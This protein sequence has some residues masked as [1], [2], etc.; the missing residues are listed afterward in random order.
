MS[1]IQILVYTGG[2]TDLY[3]RIRS[4][5]SNL[6]PAD[7][8]TVFHISADT[9]KKQPWMEPN[10][11]CLIVADTSQLDDQLCTIIQTYLS[12][13]GKVMLLCQKR[14]LADLSCCES[15][16]KQAGMIRMVF[17]PQDFNSTAKDFELFLRNSLKTLSEQGNKVRYGEA[18][19]LKPKLFLQKTKEMGKQDMP[20]VTE[21]LL[22]VGILPRSNNSTYTHFN[23]PLYFSRLKTKHL[24]RIIMHIPV[25]TTTIDICA[26]LCDAI[27][28]STGAVIVAARQTH[29]RGRSGNEFLSPLG[30]AMFNVT[31]VLPKSSSLARTPSILQ[32]VFA[33]ALVDAVHRL[34][35]LKDFPL[36]IKWP[37]DF[38]FNRSHKV[39]GLVATARSR[40]DGLLISI[41]AGINVFNSRPTV[42]LND[43]VPEGSDLKF[44]IEEVIAET[45]NRYEYWM[46][47]Y[48]MKGPAEVFEAYYKFWLHS[49]EE[50]VIENLSEKVVIC[51]LDKN[52]YLQ[53]RSKN[54]SNKIFSVGDNGNTFDMMKGL[55]RHKVC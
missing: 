12:Q 19:G 34:S 23:F 40:D 42:C 37:N 17:E 24:G 5:L 21:D 10:T 20:D 36:R 4:S 30:A 48:E 1:V 15:F 51:G 29:G 27:P 2:Q 25:A 35:G 50:V 46:N 44:N 8:Y 18:I 14:L 41:G 43:M 22:P 32:H 9:M 6:I 49:R 55:I 31:T 54:N 45:L 11:A 16:K 13:S 47:T 7:R 38:Y 28:S 3:K 39:G 53:V 26:S 33:I 52:G